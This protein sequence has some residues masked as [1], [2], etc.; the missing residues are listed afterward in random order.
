MKSQ[1]R[2]KHFSTVILLI[3]LTLT[4]LPAIASLV[5][6]LFDHRVQEELVMGQF[7]GWRHFGEIISSYIFT[8]LAVNSFTLW[9]VSFAGSLAKHILNRLKCA[10]IGNLDGQNYSHTQTNAS[11]SE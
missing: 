1:V 10:F 5:L 4:L 8:R 6:A 11:Q 7:L 3:I 2:A 9:L